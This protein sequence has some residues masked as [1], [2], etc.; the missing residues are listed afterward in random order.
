MRGIAWIGVV[1]LGLSVIGC[2][3]SDSPDTQPAGGA[4]PAAPP[5]APSASVP[6]PA[7][8]NLGTTNDAA[9]AAPEVS[10]AEPVMDSGAASGPG[11]GQA[12][13]ASGEEKGVLRAVGGALKR[14]VLGGQKP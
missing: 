6:P 7:P 11:E 2:S 14:S 13:G 12:T 5:A 8:A 3:G 9:T 1:V 4:P 10:N